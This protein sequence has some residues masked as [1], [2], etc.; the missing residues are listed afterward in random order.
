[1]KPRRDFVCLVGWAGEPDRFVSVP[2]P[3]P[4]LRGGS[5]DDENLTTACKP[6]NQSKR[7]KLLLEWPS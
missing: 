3:A 4:V 5:H 1:V 7:D 6:C 2:A